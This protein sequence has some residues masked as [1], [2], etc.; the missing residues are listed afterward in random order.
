MLLFL[1]FSLICLFIAHGYFCQNAEAE[2]ILTWNGE[3][4]AGNV[5]VRGESWVLEGCGD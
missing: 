2:A 5:H 4:V 3:H 1:R